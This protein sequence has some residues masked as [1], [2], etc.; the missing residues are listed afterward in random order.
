[1][2]ENNTSKMEISGGA[3][4]YSVAPGE[5]LEI[6]FSLTN[7]TQAAD[8]V[9]LTVD[10]IPL[11]WVA[12]EQ[13]TVHLD[14]GIEHSAK[15][16]VRV[17][18]SPNVHAGRYRVTVRSASLLNP[19]PPAEWSFGLTVAAYEA[20]GRITVLMDATQFSAIPGESMN[21]PLVLIN[22]GLTP[23][24]IRSEITKL[25]E[26]WKIS[27]PDGVKLAPEQTGE[28]TLKVE[29]PRKPDTRAGRYSFEILVHSQAAPD[30]TTEISCVLTVAVFNQ[31]SAE[32]KPVVEVEEGVAAAGEIVKV[33]VTNEGNTQE[34]FSLDLES[35]DDLLSFEPE[36]LE[37]L[38][39]PSGELSAWEFS[40]KQAKRPFFGDEKIYPYRANVS[41]GTSLTK[42]LE[43]K[44]AGKGLLPMWVLYVVGAGL[45]ILILALLFS[46]FRGGIGSPQATA[47]FTP[48]PTAT[49]AQIDQ[50]PLLVQRDWFLVSFDNNPSLAGE[51]QPFV[52]FN[53]DGTMLGN[54][55][56]NNFTGAFSTNFNQLTITNIQAAT[57]VCSNQDL[58]RQERAVIDYL[59]AAQSYFVA[60]TAMQIVSASGYLN[61]SLT[62]VN[63]PEEGVPPLAVIR[64]PAQAMV[65]QI[66][67]FDAQGSSGQ[68]P[69][70]SYRWDFGDGGRGNGALVQ[71]VFNRPGSYDVQMT[72]EDQGGLRD[73]ETHRIDILS[74]PTAIPVPT[75]TP[76]P[77]DQPTPTQ[78]PDQPTP[79]QPPEATPE[80][81]Q[82]P[83]ASP[84]QASITG[85]R[86]G[87]LGEPVRFDASASQPGSSPIT[88]FSW[89]FGDG[90]V[91]GPSDVPEISYI[92]EV[93]G[94]YDV[95]VL[96]TDQNGLS[97]QNTTTLTVDARLESQTWT[98]DFFNGQP[99]VPGTA[100][101]MQFLEGR[102]EGFAGCNTYSAEY[103]AEQ[104]E[105][106]SFRVEIT[107]VSSSR[108]SCT[109]SINRQETEYLRA[110]ETVENAIIDGNVLV[111]SFP[112]GF[113]QYRV[114][115]TPKVGLYR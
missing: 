3:E 20:K 98:L 65:D 89:D 63:R 87:F 27:L 40:P 82:P 66:V 111:L 90:N 62:P 9:R 17:P 28:V 54:T 104:N 11:V 21:I 94:V 26:G 7:N 100:I 81:T 25:P 70:V 37:P 99:L 57:N 68:T 74:A 38:K 77:P 41:S 13:S 60:D 16:T 8:Q 1:M 10:G 108:I 86:D 14:P 39:I 34:S 36:T 73:S 102:I 45:G 72:V 44:I 107:R 106:G 112:G 49:L 47:T 19:G 32:L 43:G 80:P 53:Q 103:R 58:V 50:L 35:E 115:G 29:P 46:F 79:T 23:D 15:I 113:L 42:S 88:T 91:S 97:S 24:V 59:R 30:Q 101:T 110:F 114:I 61:H 76:P 2:T 4:R 31:F 105:D 85:P 109:D 71:H 55:G 64:A 22:Q 83:Q 6:P 56:C 33:N 67:T 52:R 84:P 5:T 93:S 18:K 78:P 92:Y 51:N 96:V 95:T 69:L 12:L 75:N 48:G